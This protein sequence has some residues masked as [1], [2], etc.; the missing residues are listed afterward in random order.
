MNRPGQAWLSIWSGIIL[1]IGSVGGFGTVVAANQS[2]T[3]QSLL[4]KAERHA[5]NG[6]IYLHIEGSPVDRGFQHGCLLAPQI[7]ENLRITRALWEHDS[8]M[9]WPW[10]VERSRTL[11]ETNIDAECLGEIDGIVEGMKSAGIAT[12]RAEIIAYNAWFELDW[13]WWPK[14]KKRMGSESPHPMKQSCSSFIATGS[15][16]ADHGI[17]LGHNSMVDYPEAYFNLVLDIE[18]GRGHRILMQTAP[19][20][21]HSGTDFFVTDAGLVGS[22]TTIG[23][24]DSYDEKGIPEFVRMR[25]AT[26]DASSIDEWCDIMKRGNNGGYANAWLL[27]NINS[28]EIARLELGLNHSP[29]EKK[30]DGY[31]LGSNIAED[32]KILRFETDANE[33]DVRVSAIAR[34]VRW[35]KLMAQYTGRIDLE[36]A[37]L[38]EA[39]HHDSFLEKDHAGSRSLCGH[40]ELENQFWGSWPGGPYYPA[41]TF[42]GKVL[43]SAMAKKMSFSARWGSACGKAFNAE[44]FLAAHPQYDWMTGILKSRPAE[45]WTEFTAGEKK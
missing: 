39:D 6:W 26:Q 24:F 31:F 43:D 5:K 14:E 40:Y 36:K 29:V 33:S 41:G 18:P 17:V 45:P 22:E 25:R 23:N 38:L 8:A 20:L 35:K 12:S 30:T 10:L 27:G 15:L 44:S 32:M 3:Q 11:F 2:D 19:G 34:R 16:T 42:D 9:D 28:G 37:K 13:S 7:A 1:I 4:R 21:I